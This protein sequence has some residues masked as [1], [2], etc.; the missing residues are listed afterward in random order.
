M[1]L[2]FLCQ[3]V[4]SPCVVV[5]FFLCSCLR[6]LGNYTCLKKNYTCHLDLLII[7]FNMGLSP[8]WIFGMPLGPHWKLRINV[9]HRRHKVLRKPTFL[10]G[11]IDSSVFTSIISCFL[12]S[13]Y[14]VVGNVII[15]LK[16]LLVC[17]KYCSECFPFIN[18]LSFITLRSRWTHYPQ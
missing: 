12:M 6:T 15:A 1:E 4:F 8:L 9:R 11:N 14:Y 18:A 2:S 10:L 16:E 5:T 7:F 13:V 3:G 17:A